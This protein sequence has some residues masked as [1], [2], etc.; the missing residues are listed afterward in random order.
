MSCP[1]S[2]TKGRVLR[3]NNVA[4]RL[5]VAYRTVRWY[6]ESGQLAAFKTGPRSW[7]FHEADVIAFAARRDTIRGMV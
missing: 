4:R 7:S 2:P 1:T 3:V 5:R 6:A